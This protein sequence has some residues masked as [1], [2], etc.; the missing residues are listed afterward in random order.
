MQLCHSGYLQ[1]I[2]HNCQIK[3]FILDRH[4]YLCA[5]IPKCLPCVWQAPLLALHTAS[6]KVAPHQSLGSCSGGCCLCRGLVALGM[7]LPGGFHRHGGPMRRELVGVQAHHQDENALQVQEME[8]QL[9]VMLQEIQP[10]WWH[11]KGIQ[12][13]CVGLSQHDCFSMGSHMSVDHCFGACMAPA[14][15]LLKSLISLAEIA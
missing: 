7:Q 6:S 12:V 15:R 1:P 3:N 5:F 2:I 8:A 14:I 9:T 4:P 11:L 10:L 13:G